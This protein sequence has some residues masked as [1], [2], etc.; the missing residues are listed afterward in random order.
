MN[1]NKSDH[2]SFWEAFRYWLKLGCISF[3]GPTGQIAMMHKELVDKRKWISDNHFLQALNF[4]MLLPGPEAQQLATYIGWLQHGTWGGIVAGTLFVLPSVFV[5]MGLSWIY[6]TMGAVPTV[7]ALLYGLKPAVVAIVAEAVL[8]IAK[9]ALKNWFFVTMA[10]VSFIAIYVFSVPFPIIV[11]GAAAMGFAAKQIAPQLFGSTATT[12]SDAGTLIGGL[13]AQVR[14]TGWRPALST[15]AT[16]LTVWAIPLIAVWLW[17]GHSI[18]SDLGVLFSK[19]AMVTFGGAYAVLAYVGQEAVQ[20]FGWLQPQQ[21][22]DA[23]ALAETT[24]G[25]LIMVNQFVGYLAAYQ[26]PGDLSPATA[27][28]VGGLLTTWV[29]FAPSFLMIFLLAPYIEVLRKNALLSTALSAV[30]AAVV[31]VVLNLGV[32][33]TRNALLPDVGIFDWYALAASVV[34]FIGLQ[35]RHWPMI[36]VIIGSAGAGYLWKM[37]L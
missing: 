24:P 27:G 31:G 35:Y 32:T 22:M 37:L 34:I 17:K 33:F 6:V 12:Q 30:T 25:P 2:P 36:P 18:F 7:A 13:A 21:M 1:S 19:A 9:K 10:G 4:C 23:L 14:D 5:L 3:G 8:R 29:T 11:F 20:H 15:A 28:V 26:N 16:W